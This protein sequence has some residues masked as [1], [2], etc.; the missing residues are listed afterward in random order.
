MGYISFRVYTGD[1][2]LKR[3]GD[4]AVKSHTSDLTSCL[5]QVPFSEYI[6]LPQPKS[7]KP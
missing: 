5:E 6:A 2:V 7:P 4:R 1:S 3:H